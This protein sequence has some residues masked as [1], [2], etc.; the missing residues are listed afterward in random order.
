MGDAFDLSEEE[1][2]CDEN[3]TYERFDWND[4]PIVDSHAVYWNGQCP[5][6]GREVENY[7]SHVGILDKE[8]GASL[9]R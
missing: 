8:T 9:Q 5:D 7:Y 2:D 3:T 4:E 6:C 1:C